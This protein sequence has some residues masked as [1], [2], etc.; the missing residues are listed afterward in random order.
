MTMTS[1][2]RS[3]TIALGLIM[4][5]LATFMTLAAPAEAGEEEV[6]STSIEESKRQEGSKEIRP[7]VSSEDER[8]LPPLPDLTIVSATVVGCTVV[9]EVQNIGLADSPA[10]VEVTALD[11]TGFTQ[12]VTLPA[13]AAGASIVVGPGSPY[14]FVWP[15]SSTNG[16]V[17]VTVDWWNTLPEVDDYFNNN[18]VAVLLAGCMPEVDIAVTSATFLADCTVEFVLTNVGSVDVAAVPDAWILDAATFVYIETFTVAGPLNIGDSATFIS[19]PFTS[20]L[21]LAAGY[22]GWSSTIGDVNVGNN[23]FELDVPL[24]CVPGPDL[25]ITNL[26]WSG[27]ALWFDVEN[28]GDLDV[29]AGT[30]VSSWI[31]SAPAV[32]PIAGPFAAGASTTM[33]IGPFTSTTAVVT[34]D[35]SGLVTESDEGNNMA[36]DAVPAGCVVPEIDIQVSWAWVPGTCTA[37]VVV[38][39]AGPDPINTPFDVAI[40]SNVN[41]ISAL[42][43][44]SWTTITV[45]PSWTAAN[46]DVEVDS[47][48]DI[49][50]T[51]ESN[52]TTTITVPP[53]CL[54]SLTP[55]CG[56]AYVN[57][58]HSDG[59]YHLMRLDSNGEMDFDYGAISGLKVILDIGFQ[60]D[61][62]F[63]WAIDN[64]N[65]T[66]LYEIDL[67]SGT[68]TLITTTTNGFHGLGH[69]LSGANVSGGDS[70]LADTYHVDAIGGGTQTVMW[71]TPL[72]TT[73]QIVLD[74]T[75]NVDT[76]QYYYLLRSG[77]DTMIYETDFAGVQLNNWSVDDYE[78]L[79][80]IG[81]QLIGIDE[82][83][84][85]FDAM[86]NIPIT[87]QQPAYSSLGK[88]R[89]AA[90]F[91]DVALC[92][93][94]LLVDGSGSGS[95][96]RPAETGRA[97]HVQ[98]ST[99]TEKRGMR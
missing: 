42:T 75:L 62:L 56:T 13:I 93:P 63:A 1:H 32:L 29:P 96:S 98:H 31:N 53:S 59:T 76:A 5:M 85:Q 22:D 16:V 87:G 39:N 68:P 43:S 94:A 50:E 26:F 25:T 91:W 88:V 2:R 77:N 86:S 64:A 44:S 95:D 55:V 24:W 36:W 46:A 66:G 97:N 38:T 72:W 35:Q 45:G 61:R 48:S 12:T 81:Q 89:G 23:F 7:N 34:V 37:E 80:N 11:A 47:G 8:P 28:I 49:L 54:P 17:S 65:V 4:A 52:N 90:A 6:S 78:G 21:P 83:G 74:V 51:N 27:C 40:G 18:D 70:T 3:I 82:R 57:V 41:T 9:Y 58:W 20:A 79:A 60:G 30:S 84:V 92:G 33:A 19:A 14:S 10:G 69:G 73:S 99:Q 67:I 71:T 15:S